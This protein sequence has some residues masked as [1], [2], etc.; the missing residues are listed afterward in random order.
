MYGGGLEVLIPLIVFG[1]IV[2]VVALPIVAIVKAF[3]VGSQ[4]EALRGEI[5][6]L[7]EMLRQR[8][9]DSAQGLPVAAVRPPPVQQP[10]AAPPAPPPPQPAAQ[11]FAQP[12]PPLPPQPPAASPPQPPPAPVVPTPAYQQ[13]DW[14]TQPVPAKSRTLGEWEVLIGGNI[15]N[16]IA[17]VG[18]IIVAAL[19]L[20]WAYDNDWITQGMI[21]AFGFAVGLALLY[22]GSRFHRGG[23][24]VFAQGLL[25]AG[26]AILYLAGYAT[27]AYQ[28][29]PQSA[30]FVVM[31]L[32]TAAALVQALQY[33]SLVVCLLGLVGGF[34]TP[35]LLGGGSGAGGVNHFGLF[36]YIALLDAGLLAVALAKDDWAAIEPLALAGTYL[37]YVVWHD[38]YYNASLFAT[39]MPFVVVVWL[40]FCAADLCRIARSV[41]TFSGLRAVLGV[42]NSLFFYF[43]LYD[44]IGSRLGYGTDAFK[45]WMAFAT[46]C[47]GV[48]YLVGLVALIRR[49]QD[50]KFVARYALTASVLLVTATAIEFDG[51]VRVM[52]WAAEAV[53]LVWCGLRWSSRSTLWAGIVM[54]AVSVMALLAQDQAFAWM[55]ANH[56]VPVWNLRFA[57]FAGVAAVFGLIAYLFARSDVEE[58]ESVRAVYE[59]GCYVLILVLL[60]VEAND[61]FRKLMYV[62]VNEP[63]FSLFDYAR[64]MAIG[65]A[66]AIY[67]LALA[68]YGAVR[69][70]MLAKCFGLGALGL[71]ALLV[72]GNGFNTDPTSA[73]APV[74]NVRAL[75]FGWVFVALLVAQW[76][77][78][79]A[80]EEDD[81]AKPLFGAFRIAI[82]VLALEL[83][84]VETYRL[85]HYPNVWRSISAAG[86]SAEYIDDL[87]LGAAWV[88]YS[89]PV[90]W[91]GLKE[92]SRALAGIGLC[93][94]GAGVL[95]IAAGGFEF[96]PIA[97]FRLVANA[98]FAAFAIAAAGLILNYGLLKERVEDF[99]WARGLLGVTR[100][101]TSLLLFELVTA[102]TLDF[103]ASTATLAPGAQVVRMSENMRAMT[104]SVVWLIYS[105]ALISFGFA[106]RS[107][108]IRFV[109]MI[110]FAIAIFK[111]FLLDL[112][113]L[114]GLYRILSFAGLAVILFATSYLYQ[115][116][117]GVI[118]ES[119]EALP[120]QS[121]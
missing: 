14:R 34:L 8:A 33:D 111:V 60:A 42:A 90:V 78:A 44:L 52:L 46:L 98:R 4:V 32:V 103:F 84:S 2:V 77:Y 99:G 68:A 43:A 113:F 89:L 35:A 116:Y 49:S 82:S 120:E 17:A 63:R 80:A 121:A 85:F 5:A 73:F 70:S 50:R 3:S 30:A 37:T 71:G 97:K 117:R 10:T 55:Q 12:P 119:D 16:R 102:E 75:G 66:W 100:V 58:K 87:A 115:Q 101:V 108:T 57:A 13:A 92:R 11:P 19:F 28:L 40:L 61:Y 18:L 74:L 114:E 23:A 88:I 93:A 106:A 107:R 65:C 67:A 72:A 109:A 79:R 56:F 69:K 83:L 54:S 105:F 53:G 45:H 118:L 91:F 59:S 1:I 47:I 20:K 62:D 15:V 38:A 21:T 25:G 81:W 36:A 26:I 86:L 96:D 51:F 39:A 27:F 76:I 31:A 41:V 9:P 104:L 24:E 7:R 94:L 22:V 29:I 6:R 64:Y 112:S 110:L 95:V 48:V